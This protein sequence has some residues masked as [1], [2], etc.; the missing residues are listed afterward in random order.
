MSLQ[1]FFP[2]VGIYV[3][4]TALVGLDSIA[5]GPRVL[6]SLERLGLLCARGIAP[7]DKIA[8]GWSAP[9]ALG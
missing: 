8:A 4:P 9:D 7:A 6:E 3:S 1:P 5:E 2:T